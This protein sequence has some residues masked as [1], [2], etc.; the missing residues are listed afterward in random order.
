[1]Q[2]YT[3]HPTFKSVFEKGAKLFSSFIERSAK[4]DNVSKLFNL[5][6]IRKSFMEGLHNW[7]FSTLTKW[8]RIYLNFS[9]QEKGN[10]LR[11]L[12]LDIWNC[13]KSKLFDDFFFFLLFV[14]DNFLGINNTHN[15]KNDPNME[16]KDL[17]HA[18]FYGA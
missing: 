12:L 9:A 5:Y 18:K 8:F 7:L 16:N 11:E 4:I 10:N 13:T 1:M 15:M 17:L 14:V 3:R 2:H 6:I